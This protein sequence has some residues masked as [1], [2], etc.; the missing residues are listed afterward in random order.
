MVFDLVM[1]TEKLCYKGKPIRPEEQSK[2][3]SIYLAILEALIKLDL[4][5]KNWIKID[6]SVYKGRALPHGGVMQY[7]CS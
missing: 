1:E 6:N 2:A 3:W 5:K 7:E 4:E